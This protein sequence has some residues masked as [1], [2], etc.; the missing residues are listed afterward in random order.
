MI[1]PSSQITNLSTSLL[2]LCV[3]VLI[4][5]CSDGRPSRIPVSGKVTIDGVPLS[6]GSI[7]FVGGTGRPSRGA[8]QPDGKFSLMTYEPGDGCPPGT[9]TVAITSTQQ[10]DE[11]TTKFFAPQKYADP[12]T[13]GISQTVDAPI[14]N[15]EIT[16]TWK[17]SGHTQPFIVKEE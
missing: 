5:G 2:T 4:C 14:E 13:S 3:F 17:G 15:L 7:Q 11:T 8:I 12:K 9:Y 1:K 10:I 6:K 16:L